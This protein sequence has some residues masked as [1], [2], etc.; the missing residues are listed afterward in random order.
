MRVVMRASVTDWQDAGVRR[1]LIAG[2]LV[3]L[4][5]PVARSFVRAGLAGVAAEPSRETAVRAV[6]ERKRGR[7]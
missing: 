6:P 7:S 5:E 2:E 3:D 1:R 4:P